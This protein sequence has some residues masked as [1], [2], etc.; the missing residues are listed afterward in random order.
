MSH[1]K[2]IIE[3]EIVSVDSPATPKK[4]FVILANLCLIVSF[5]LVICWDRDVRK[6]VSP[7]R[8]HKSKKC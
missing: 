4:C 3:F 8:R 1:S 7:N 2:E 5:H 6:K